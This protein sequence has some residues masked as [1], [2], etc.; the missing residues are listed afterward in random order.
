MQTETSSPFK[1]V[2]DLSLIE[3]D[4]RLNNKI[5]KSKIKIAVVESLI[6]AKITEKK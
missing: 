1:T 6:E 5:L 3:I 2:G 4:C